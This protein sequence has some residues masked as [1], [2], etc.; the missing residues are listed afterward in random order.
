MNPPASVTTYKMRTLVP[1]LV[2]A[3]AVLSAPAFAQPAPST[4][5]VTIVRAPEQVR[6]TVEQW[7]AKERCTIALQV[8]IVPTEGGLYLLATDEHGRV[9]ERIVP[10][11]SSAGVLIASWAA[12]DG[13]AQPQLPAAPPPVYA[14]PPPYAGPQQ[15]PYQAGAAPVAAFGPGDFRPHSRRVDKDDDDDDDMVPPKPTYPQKF[16]TVGAGLGTNSSGGVRVEADFANWG[17]WTLT[18]IG[19]ITSTEL[20]TYDYNSTQGS[21]EDYNAKIVDYVVGLDL[22]HIWHIGGWHIRGAIG[23]GLAFST[24]DLTQYEYTTGYTTGGSGSMTSPYVETNLMVGHSFG[25]HDQWALELGPLLS[26]TQQEWYVAENMAT[27]TRNGGNAMFVVG[28]RH[29]L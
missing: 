22:G 23:A 12:D 25:E 29:G 5:S 2:F 4:C 18:A 13:L 3:P 1:A 15:F 17:G 7:L 21:G 19:S 9:R 11:A 24:M 28:L 6:A 20:A 26:F 8:R 27:M 16:L 14:P 10:D